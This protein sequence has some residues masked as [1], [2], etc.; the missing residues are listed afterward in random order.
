MIFES[1]DLLKDLMYMAW[2]ST[3]LHLTL[4]ILDKVYQMVRKY[5]YFFK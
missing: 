3:W 2:T 5:A 1:V 4:D